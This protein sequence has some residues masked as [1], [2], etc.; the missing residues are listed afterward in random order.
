MI[1]IVSLPMR[2]EVQF[3]SNLILII[4]ALCI[5][6][7]ADDMVLQTINDCKKQLK[8]DAPSAAL[9]FCKA[10]YDDL[11]ADFTDETAWNTAMG[12][13]GLVTANANPNDLVILNGISIA[14]S[15]DFKDENNLRANG[16]ENVFGGITYKITITDPNV[17][18]DNHDIYGKLI[19]GRKAYVVMAFND[20]SMEVS[21]MDFSLRGKL[22]NT[23]KG[24]IQA[25]EAIGA[26]TFVDSKTWLRFDTQPAGI[27]DLDA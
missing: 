12:I 11:A 5:N 22:P 13:G 10:V 4:M 17:N 1:K 26:R 2:S 24:G 25:Y 14:R 16:E 9:I 6:T 20:G 27:F 7:C 23:E 8:G 15:S 3:I 18:V 19:N 21:E